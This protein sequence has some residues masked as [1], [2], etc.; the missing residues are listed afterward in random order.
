M[1][2]GNPVLGAANF[3]PLDRHI[4]QH[5]LGKWWNRY[6]AMAHYPQPH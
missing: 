3:E 6:T 2:L 4:L 1:L 5:F